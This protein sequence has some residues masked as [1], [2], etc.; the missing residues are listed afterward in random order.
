[1]AT[2]SIDPRL[3]VLMAR[4]SA[5]VAD[6]LKPPHGLSGNTLLMG[7]GPDRIVAR[8][9]PDRPFPWVNRRREYQLLRKLQHREIAPQALGW[10]APWLLVSYLAGEP[11]SDEAFKT[12]P[13]DIATLLGHVHHQPLSGYRFSLTA[14]LAQYWQQCHQHTPQWLARWRQLRRRGEPRP[15]RLALLHMDVHPGNVIDNGKT[16]RLIDWEYAGDGDVAMELAAVCSANQLSPV[17]CQQLVR[18]Y[19]YNNHIGEKQL[20]SQVAAWQP[21]LRLLMACWYQLWAERSG[22]TTLL[23]YAATRWKTA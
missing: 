2:Y 20:I 5:P 23:Q 21:W 16:L 19:A 11:L 14:L 17:H 3:R 10:H 12:R 18:C 15:L 6:F 9:Q 22:D 1:M 7:T 8:T 4:Q 13:E